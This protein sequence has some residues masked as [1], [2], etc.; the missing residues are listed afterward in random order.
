[1]GHDLGGC[2]VEGVGVVP[3][4]AHGGDARIVAHFDVERAA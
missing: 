3:N 2:H 1:M 4:V